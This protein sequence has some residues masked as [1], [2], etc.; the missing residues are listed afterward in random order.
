MHN[1]IATSNKLEIHY[2]YRFLKEHNLLHKFTH[3]MLM[4]ES[5][6]DDGSA[7][8]C[9]YADAYRNSN[10]NPI[11]H[12]SI[13]MD[14]YREWNFNALQAS[15]IWDLSNEGHDFWKNINNAYTE[16]KMKYD[17]KGIL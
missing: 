2:L 3:N 1:N 8:T 15:F 16:Y 12:I 6:Y 9:V 4:L 11:A 5:I 10:C 13:I 14:K 7:E 17:T